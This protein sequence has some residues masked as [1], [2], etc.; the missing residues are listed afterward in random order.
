MY[1]DCKPVIWGHWLQTVNKSYI[2]VQLFQQQLR[3]QLDCPEKLL[4]LI[5]ECIDAN[6]LS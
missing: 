6:K 4:H 1:A 5:P 2:L 3:N